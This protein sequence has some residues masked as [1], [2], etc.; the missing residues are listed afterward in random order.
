[1]HQS[2]EE[3]RDEEGG[4][5]GH[6]KGDRGYKGVGK[7]EESSEEG[8]AKEGGIGGEK[9]AAWSKDAPRLPAT[10]QEG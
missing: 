8:G 6:Y 10:K 4:N 7:G 3:D 1:M 2:E 5:A 9:G